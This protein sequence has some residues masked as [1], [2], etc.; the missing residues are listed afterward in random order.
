VANRVLPA[1]LTP[2]SLTA[3]ADAL[4]ANTSA[5]AA[6]AL[7]S[8]ATAARDAAALADAQ[9]VALTALRAHAPQLL[10]T[11]VSPPGK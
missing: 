3:A 5:I 2:E 4:T 11:T 9:R 6:S 10:L 8:A 7:A 1:H